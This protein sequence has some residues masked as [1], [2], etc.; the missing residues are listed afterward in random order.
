MFFFRIYRLDN[1][2]IEKYSILCCDTVNSWNE[3]LR[4]MFQLG[5]GFITF[6]YTATLGE[7]KLKKTKRITTDEA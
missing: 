7:T 1:K 4:Q 6:Q 2:I 3:L 5:K